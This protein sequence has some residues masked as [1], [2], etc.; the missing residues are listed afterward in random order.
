MSIE[1]F[2]RFVREPFATI[3]TDTENI[4][5]AAVWRRAFYLLK[6]GHSMYM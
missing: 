2:L 6:N 5:L 4:L 1:T 3:H